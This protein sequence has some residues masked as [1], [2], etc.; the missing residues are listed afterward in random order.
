[1]A[2]DVA[3]RP[4]VVDGGQAADHGHPEH[5]DPVQ[6]ADGE[7]APPP[8][9]RRVDRLEVDG[10]GRAVHD[11]VK[12][13]A[14]L[15]LFRGFHS[16]DSVLVRNFRKVPSARELWLLTVPSLHPSDFAVS[17]WVRSSR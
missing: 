15:G 17:T 10:G 13:V 1:M 14:E 6:P 11:A 12:I 7:A 2:G 4:A 8:R 9:W 5:G 16:F 3:R